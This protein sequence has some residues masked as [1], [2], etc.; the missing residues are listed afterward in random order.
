M[1][2]THFCMLYNNVMKQCYVKMLYNI[3]AANMD[4]QLN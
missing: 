4:Q 2:Y 3:A 1:L